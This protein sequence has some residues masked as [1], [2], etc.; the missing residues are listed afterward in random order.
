MS[1]QQSSTS[2]RN[3]R[4]AKKAQLHYVNSFDEGIT[5][6]RCGK[7]FTYVSANGKTVRA[8]QTRK[9]ID[10]LVIPPAWEDV[11]ICPKSNGHIQVRGRDEAGRI[12]YI[13]H[14]RW[15]AVSAARK[16]DRLHLMAELLPRIRRRVRKD[17]G[18]KKLSKKRVLAAVVRLLDKAKM[19]IGNEQYAETSGARG[20]TT[21]APE[22]VEIENFSVTLDYPSKSGKHREIEF[23]NRK[24]AK[25]LSECEELDGQYLFCYHAKDDRLCRVDSTDVNEYLSEITSKGVS[26]KD[27]RTWW[28][29]VQTL[30]ALADID[31]DLT[32]RKRKSQIN[33][34]IE[35]AASLLGNTKAV[36]RK[37][38][39]HP[40]IIAAAESGE[41]PKLLADLSIASVE[42]QELSQDEQQFAALLPH[43]EFS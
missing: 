27:F 11:W 17:L 23:S 22:H 21:I 25:V 14:E 13:Y 2:E 4:R 5:R 9:R 26:A 37:S 33:R 18:V 28:G 43:L 8:K 34:A 39:V 42:N 35:S 19:R 15:Q 24:V 30:S 3:Q 40:G 41:L 32:A 10:N 20:A 38:Y 6:R 12:Q 29:S 1:T 16:F 31:P 36:C 7:G